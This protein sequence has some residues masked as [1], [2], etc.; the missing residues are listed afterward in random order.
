M[1]DDFLLLQTFS[2]LIAWIALM[3]LGKRTGHKSYVDYN[4]YFN[5]VNHIK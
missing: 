5:C 4:Y 2:T 1:T 3:T